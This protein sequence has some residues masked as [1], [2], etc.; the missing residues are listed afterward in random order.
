[1]PKESMVM[2]CN[3]LNP[4][5]YNTTSILNYKCPFGIFEIYL[6]K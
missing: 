2:S 1:M 6:K 3:H 5:N 4:N